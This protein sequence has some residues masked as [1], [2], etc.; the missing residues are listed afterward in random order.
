MI[1]NQRLNENFLFLLPV[2]QPFMKAPSKD[3]KRKKCSDMNTSMSEKREK[4]QYT[5]K[6]NNKSQ[7]DK[8]EFTIF[9]L[10]NGP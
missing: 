3:K 1:E 2:L 9:V 5:Q 7:L 10:K 8:S 6:T 4:G